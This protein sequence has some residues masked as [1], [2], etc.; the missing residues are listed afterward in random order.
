[1]KKTIFAMVIVIF[2]LIVVGRFRTEGAFFDIN[3]ALFSVII[4]T[5]TMAAFFWNF[6]RKVASS[7]EIALIA[8]MAALAAVSRV[9]FVAI[10]SFQ[11]TTFIVMITGYVFGP[12]SGFLVG[13]VAAL[14]SNFF[15]GQGPWTPWQMLGWGLC[16]V[17]AGLLA[18]KRQQE[19][20]LVSFTLL[21]GFCGFFFGWVMN[22]WHWVGFVYPLNL[23]TF[24]ATYLASLPFDAI[25][26]AANI[27]FCLLFGKSF[28]QVLLRFQKKM[29]CEIKLPDQLG[30]SKN[31]AR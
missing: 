25:H 16:G 17:L 18:G 5:L 12:Q 20:K 24:I 3:W 11:P 7:K 4:L 31:R 9:P 23:Q 6:E 26:A 22:I 21:G 14:V 8:T 2:L 15:L 30:L 10:T 27:I 29:L 19:F 28:Y 13:A 1:M